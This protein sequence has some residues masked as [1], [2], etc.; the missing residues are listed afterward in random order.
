MAGWR[1]ANIVAGEV[2]MAYRWVHIVDWVGIAA[3]DTAGRPP[4]SRDT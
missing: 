4:M 3:G 1:M 2:D